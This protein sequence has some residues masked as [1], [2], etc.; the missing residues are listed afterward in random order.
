M[1]V[2]FDLSEN[3]LKYFRRVMKDVRERA[4]DTSEETIVAAA[5]ELLE[6]VREMEVPDFVSDRIERLAMLIDMLED[7]EWALKG[8]DRE[9]VLRGMAYFAEPEDMIP[10]GVP[11]LGLLD[12]AIMIELVVTELGHEIEAY[13]D[14][15]AFRARREKVAGKDEDPASRNEWLIS[16]RKQLHSRMRRRRSR[17]G[18]RGGGGGGKSPISL[19]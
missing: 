4:K 14:F 16:R 19:W 13:E 1:R 2:S 9:R 8:T 15:C 3:D 12:D 18:S 5:R 6:S 17:R 10:D 7:E 11:V